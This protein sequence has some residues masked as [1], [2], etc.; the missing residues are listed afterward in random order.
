MCEPKTNRQYHNINHA[1]LR[2]YGWVRHDGETFGRQEIVDGGIT[3][4][5]S[6]VRVCS[7]QQA[8]DY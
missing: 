2:R 7:V 1:G 6:L 8:G 4:T 3:L 5:T